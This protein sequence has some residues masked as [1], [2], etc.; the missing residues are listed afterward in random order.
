MTYFSNNELLMNFITDCASRWLFSAWLVSP[1]N[2][3]VC[4]SQDLRLHFT[5]SHTELLLQSEHRLAFPGKLRMLT[6]VPG[7][8]INI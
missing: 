7:A 2:N 4:K 1:Q 5:H 6:N 3:V 8:A